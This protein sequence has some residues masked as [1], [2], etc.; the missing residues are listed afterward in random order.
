MTQEQPNSN[1]EIRPETPQIGIRFVAMLGLTGALFLLAASHPASI[2]AAWAEIESIIELKSTPLPASPARLSEHESEALDSMTPQQQAQRLLERAINHYDGAIELI[3]LR[4]GGWYGRLKL[5]PEFNGLLDAAINSNDL[6]VRAASIEIYL[7]AYNLPKTTESALNLLDRIDQDP[8]WRPFGLWMLGALA[9]RG[10]EPERLQTALFNRLHD[11]DENTRR[12]TVEGIALLGTNASIEPLLDAFHN[13]ASPTVREHA[14]CG[15]AQSGMLTKEQRM[16]AV[17]E[18]LKFTDDPSLDR[19][20]Q[21]WAF[22]ALR[23]ITG[24]S[25]G[26]D[27]PAWRAWWSAHSQG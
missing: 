21:I 15:L 20:T 10:V 17:P 14:A 22:Q 3:D 9:N 13:D 16:T 19:A 8:G 6:R 24:A 11:P 5:D 4:V 26:N 12:W 2:R 7:A 25:I 1:G 27:S 18:I 23:D